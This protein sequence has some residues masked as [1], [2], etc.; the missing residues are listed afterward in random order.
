MEDYNFNKTWD[1]LDTLNEDAQLQLIFDEDVKE[2]Q[3]LCKKLIKDKVIAHTPNEKT[4]KMLIQMANIIQQEDGKIPYSSLVPL[5]TGKA[6]D[7]VDLVF[8]VAIARHIPGKG[9]NK[10]DIRPF[11]DA[12]TAWRVF[13]KTRV[14]ED[15]IADAMGFER[16]DY[17]ETADYFSAGYGN[18]NPDLVDPTNGYTFDVK[19]FANID[20]VNEL[21]NRNALF[22]LLTNP[23]NGKVSLYIK[24][25]KDGQVEPG[26]PSTAYKL[27]TKN[28]VSGNLDLDNAIKKYLVKLESISV[29]ARSDSSNKIPSGLIDGEELFTENNFKILDALLAC[30][31]FEWPL[32]KK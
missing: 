20:R 22:I 11:E 8:A 28:Y 29:P 9:Q 23:S 30:L 25:P 5:A 26:V 6:R 31:G 21:K 32:E 4:I 13:G 18:F 14:D 16:D 1:E 3:E 19:C 24:E 15:I 17:A 27:V 2:V 7:L 10:G 12:L